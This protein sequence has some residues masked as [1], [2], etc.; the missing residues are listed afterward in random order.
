MFAL[1]IIDPFFHV[2]GYKKVLLKELCVLIV[3]ASFWIFYCMPF[4][5]SGIPSISEV[6]VKSSRAQGK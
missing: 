4:N 6:C 1:K 5:S 2:K 3:F